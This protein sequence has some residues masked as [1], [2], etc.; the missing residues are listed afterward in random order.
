MRRA[1]VFATVALALCA[2]TTWAQVRPV[3]PPRRDSARTRADTLR[4]DSTA[5]DSTKPKDLIKWNEPDSVMRALM[6]RA[7][8]TATRYQGDVAVFNAQTHTLALKGKKAGVNRDK[9]VIVG[10]S[11][12]YNDSTKIMFARGDTV[13]LR[14]P[15]QQPDD[16]YARGLM[17]YNIELHRGVVTNITTAIEQTGQHWI[18]YGKDA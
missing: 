17:A 12:I 18:V 5:A 4:R 2:H 11:I 16:V 7:G 13:I 15:E 8:Y 3:V 6:D 10:D 1:I 14:D 9:T